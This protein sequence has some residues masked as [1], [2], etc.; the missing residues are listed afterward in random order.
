VPRGSERSRAMSVFLGPLE[1]SGYYGNL[2]SGFRELGV[3][4]RLVTLQPN[5][6]GF[7][8]AQRN[9]WPARLAQ[10]T[11]LRHRGA[12]AP[13]RLVTGSLYVAASVLLLFWTLRR[14]DSYIFS[15]GES[16]LPRNADLPLLRLLRKNVVVVLGHGSEAR[17]PYMSTP[18]DGTPPFSTEDVRRLRDATARVAAKVRKAERWSTRVIGLPTT[19]QF[20]RRP[21]VD[22]YALGIPTAAATIQAAPAAATNAP[23]VVL[24]VPSKPAVKG[25]P[26]IRE[27]METICARH[28]EVVFRELSGRPHS[29]IVAAIA[30]CTFV[31][32]QL[33]SDIP[34][35]VVGTEAAT[36][37]KATVIAGYAWDVWDELLSPD[38]WPPTITTHP[39]LL[40][41]TIERCVTDPTAVT[42]IGDD[43]R[44]F[45]AER[46]SPAAVA[47]RYREILRGDPA[48][49][50]LVDP[51]DIRYAYGCGASSDDV[52][53]MVAA[54]ADAYGAAALRWPAAR[55][56]YGLASGGAE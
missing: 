50:T 42:T 36:L 33:W 54:L 20:L 55:A 49:G 48:A 23:I 30:E 25:S 39:D 34:M 29:E 5:P 11:V 43:A 4:A 38:E 13:L 1:I 56:A 10:W 26:R 7:E 52:D 35:A 46:W 44:R 12:S 45:V 51:A 37:G 14:F 24:H 31:V 8:Q 2:E 18:A 15:W 32:D 3:D 27:T 47:A 17:P 21:F 40:L 28:P 9:P 53:A 41:E 16:I 19:A 6:F 22:F